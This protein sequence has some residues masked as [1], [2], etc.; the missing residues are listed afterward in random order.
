MRCS[1]PYGRPTTGGA[2][3]D[4]PQA[5]G[6]MAQPILALGSAVDLSFGSRLRRG[7]ERKIERLL[8]ELPNCRDG[9]Q[10]E[11]A[12]HDCLK[13]TAFFFFGPHEQGVGR[14]VD[15]VISLVWIHKEFWLVAILLMQC[16]CQGPYKYYNRLVLR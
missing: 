3:P 16:P 9:T 15:F 7:R 14:F 2:A 1:R 12:I 4:R 8:R 5:G 11:E 6:Y 10:H 13:Q